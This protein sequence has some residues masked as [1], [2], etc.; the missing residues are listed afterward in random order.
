MTGTQLPV[1]DSQARAIEE[2]AKATQK[3]LG[4]L[5]GL[6][7]Y[8][9]EVLGTVPADLV[10]LLGGDWLKVRRAENLHD[11]VQRM[12]QKLEARNVH[13]APP[14]SMSL[15]LPIMIAA[16]D[17]SRDELKDLWAALLAAATDPNRS[18][19][20]RLA[21][22]SIVKSMDPL[23]TSSLKAI[24]EQRKRGPAPKDEEGA[25]ATALKISKDEFHVSFD[26]LKRLGLVQHNPVGHHVLTSLGREF[27][28]AVQE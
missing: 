14:P 24:A 19:G 20:F 10:G 21:F 7:G 27:L 17:E 18:K 13:N 1:S 25:L 9:R 23:D 16:A 26:N 15:A 2:S 6:G 28:R 5:E 4:V 3:A 12:K 8:F 22:I 11:I